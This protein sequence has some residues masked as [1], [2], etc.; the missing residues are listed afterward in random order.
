[1]IPEYRTIA[2]PARIEYII[3]KSRFIANAAPI[4]D[5]AQ[6]ESVLSAVK[7]EY[8]DATHYCYAYIFGADGSAMKYSDGGEPGGTAGLPILEVLKKQN[9][10]ECI[11][12]V[13]RYYGGIQLGAGGLARAYSH[14]AAEAVKAAGIALRTYTDE[15]RFELDYPL[16]AKI[17]NA[18]K[19]YDRIM[20]RSVE[21]LEK[22]IYTVAVRHT[23]IGAVG[24]Y[25][26][27]ISGGAAGLAVLGSGYCDW[28]TEKE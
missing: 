17:E 25:I 21:Y 5:A 18:L 19:K 12:V 3:N 13:T 7:S 23:D 4:S 15:Y 16:H 14:A 8:K 10:T 9:L 26:T 6:A 2:R 24:G 22:V 1:M 20:I 11:V 28:I 27:E